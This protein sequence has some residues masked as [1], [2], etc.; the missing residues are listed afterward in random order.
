ML[1]LWLL[2]PSFAAD[3]APLPPEAVSAW[4]ELDRVSRLRARFEQ[5]QHRSVLSR[6]LVS[7]GTL[8]FERPNR[9]RWGSRSPRARCS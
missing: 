7:T 1:W 4:A 3:P 9:V 6:P 2:L 8:S 5:V